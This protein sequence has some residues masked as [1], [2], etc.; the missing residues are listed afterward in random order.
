MARTTWFRAAF[1]AAILLLA[2]AAVAQDAKTDAA[3]TGEP[4]LD[5]I[6]DGVQSFYEKTD[7]FRASFKQAIKKRYKPGAGIERTGTVYFLKPGKMRWDYKTPEPVYYV[8]DG[9]TL[10]VYEQRENTAYKG[11][12]RDSKMASTMKF[13]FG[14]GKLRDEFDITLGKAPREGTYALDMTPK[15]GQQGYK[16]LVL[17]VDAK[18][19][20]IRESRL[21]DPADDVSQ[22]VFSDQT[23]AKIENPE[24]FDWK[25]GP[26]VKVQDLSK[27]NE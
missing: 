20:E 17:I 11:D 6:V 24:W 14:A 25:P 8:T 22:I 19:Y 21:T 3:P 16:K 10:W 15:S 9:A 5:Q 1:G 4:S 7:S 26:D 23:Y 13:L 12:I 27:L 2:T 18:T